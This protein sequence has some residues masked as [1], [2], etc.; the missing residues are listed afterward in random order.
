[1]RHAEIAANARRPYVDKIK[2]DQITI[3][4][5][6]SELLTLAKAYDELLTAHGNAFGWGRLPAENARALVAEVRAN[7]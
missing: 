1:M 3:D 4:E 2:R 5:C 7:R 6:L